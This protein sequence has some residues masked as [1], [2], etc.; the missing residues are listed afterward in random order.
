MDDPRPT[1]S[2]WTGVLCGLVLALAVA[3][4]KAQ[5]AQQ[6]FQIVI[7][8]AGNDCQSIET[9]R[10]IGT[11]S[12]R[13]ALVAVACTNGGRHVVSIHRDNSVSYM[14]SCQAF[15]AGTGLVC[16]NAQ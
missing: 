3:P 7:T 15:E 2:A 4:A 9:T 13:D 10:A 5:L 11:G 12:N 1:M 16:F 8:R 6:A 14:S